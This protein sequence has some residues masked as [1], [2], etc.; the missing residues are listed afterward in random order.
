MRHNAQEKNETLYFDD[1]KLATEKLQKQSALS[2]ESKYK[3]ES[4][5]KNLEEKEK[6]KEIALEEY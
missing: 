2:K 3:K 5:I 1:N 6:D 4:V